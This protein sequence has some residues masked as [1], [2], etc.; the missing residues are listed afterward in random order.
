MLKLMFLLIRRYRTLFNTYGTVKD[1]V[2]KN[3]EIKMK[4]KFYLCAPNPD[5]IPVL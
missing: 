2:L 1:R 5:P 3:V 4:V